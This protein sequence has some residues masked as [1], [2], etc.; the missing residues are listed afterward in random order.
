M[1][2]K[3]F[4]HLAVWPETTGL[5][6]APHGQVVLRRLVA[7]AG[8]GRFCGR[9]DGGLD[10]WDLCDDPER[11]IGSFRVASSAVTSMAFNQIYYQ[12]NMTS[13]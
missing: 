12:E 10:V 6:V 1:C 13:Y 4:P 8:G 11:P 3:T 9:A 7:D 2:G 5:Q